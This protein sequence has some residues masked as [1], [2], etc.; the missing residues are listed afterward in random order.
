MKVVTPSYSCISKQIKLMAFFA[1]LACVCCT[2][3]N[4]RADGPD[5]TDSYHLQFAVSTHGGNRSRADITGDLP[6]S[7]AE[8]YINVAGR[9]LQFLLF[10]G[11]R[12]FLQ[13]LSLTDVQ[14]VYT[15]SNYIQYIFH[16]PVTSQYFKDNINTT[17]SF[18]I[19]ALANGHS[20]GMT[21]PV[22]SVGQTI[23]DIV[24]GR[25]GDNTG[26]ALLTGKPNTSHLMSTG[27]GDVQNFPMAGLQ[28]FTVSGPELKKSTEAIPYNISANGKDINML[29][30]LA[31]IEVID[32]ANFTGRYNETTMSRN[33]IRVN[34]VEINGFMNSGSIIPSIG[35][36]TN[37]DGVETRQVDNTTVPSGAS[38]M[39]PVTMSI[40]VQTNPASA[41]I[42]FVL[43]PYAKSIEEDNCNVFSGYVYEYD[44]R[45]LLDTQQKPYLRITTLGTQTGTVTEGI[46]V[47]PMLLATYTDGTA[48]EPVASLLR[49]HIYRFKIVAINNANLTVQW[50]V[51]PMDQVS[52][53]IP[54]FD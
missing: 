36:W 53:N 37:E 31:K 1:L 6:G 45:R 22:P 13:E 44:I 17:F 30:A 15:A 7:T 21:Y 51:C 41:T 8:N 11:D 54:S 2:D 50:T 43:D 23:E 19:M 20:M 12:K 49:N 38:Y 29:R 39:A 48:G 28:K 3:G 14:L 32:H 25:G 18:Y 40:P 10:D 5:F 47:I 52:V 33:R 27:S 34:K 4:K 42:E 26:N 16:A 24:Q 46:D 35:E 9:D